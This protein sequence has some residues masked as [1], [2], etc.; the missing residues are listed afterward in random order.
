MASSSALLPRE[1]YDVFLSFS[2]DTLNRFVCYI[3]DALSR[4]KIKAY[5]NEDSVEKGDD[6][7]ISAACLKAI[8][9]SK[10]L[11]IIFSENYAFSSRC[12]EELVQILECK[13]KDKLVVP[14]FYH[15][16]PSHVRRQ[17]GSYAAA[18][19]AHENHFRDSE[20]DHK[21]QKWREALQKAADFSGWDSSA[22]GS[23]SRLVEG[24]VNDIVDK[25]H[26]M[27]PSDDFKDLIGIHKRMEKVETLLDISSL[28]VRFIVIL[29]SEGIGKTTL[30]RAI[31]NRFASQFDGY[32]FLENIKEELKKNG[33]HDIKKQ[34]ISEL[35]KERSLNRVDFLVKDRLRS[36]KV[37]VVLDDIVDVE[38]L[39]FLAADRE[40]F[41]HGSRIIITTRDAQLLNYI[42]IDGTYEVEELNCDEALQL[43]HSKAFG[44][45][46]PTSNYEALSKRVIDYAKGNPLVL[47]DLGCRLCSRSTK[48]WES[49]LC[50]LER[51][52]NNNSKCVKKKLRS[53]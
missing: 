15:V 3:S 12:L 5:I 45:N 8:Q 14:V 25:L 2:E 48:E 43:F 42:E 40:W 27:S 16:I 29:G 49:Q 47:K 36:S 1:K 51:N 11:V 4:K 17:K 37:L 18:F 10:V 53:A 22:I 46:S 31:F 30:A 6:H 23:E 44:G 39:E 52:P 13:K 9:E 26:H 28:G 24:I 38:Q 7:E 20:M 19:V 35:L 41:G 32:C 33:L 21:V 34:L 50:K